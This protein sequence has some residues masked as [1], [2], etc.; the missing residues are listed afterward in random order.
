MGD[1]DKLTINDVTFS[2]DEYLDTS[3]DAISI[4]LDTYTDTV[5]PTYTVSTADTSTITLSEPTW[6][7]D[8]NKDFIDT[9]PNVHRVDEMCKEYPA[10]AKAYE[11]F[12]SIYKMCDQDY[13][14]K[15]KAQG[16]DDDIPF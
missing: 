12:K 14:G 15:L 2:L 1:D 13:K 5:A 9:M 7:V 16:L 8:Y 6:T 3:N 4:T 10:L 11:T